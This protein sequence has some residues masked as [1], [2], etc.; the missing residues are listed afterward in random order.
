[1]PK[2]ALDRLPPCQ[3]ALAHRQPDAGLLARLFRSL[4]APPARNPELD[5]L[6]EH[7]LR[8]VGYRPAAR[9][10]RWTDL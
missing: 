6:S 10:S 3:S 2:V 4:A 8:D 7:L 1:M 5:R 9:P